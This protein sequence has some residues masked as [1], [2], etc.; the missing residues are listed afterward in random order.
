VSAEDASGA[1]PL[2]RLRNVRKVYRT[3][4]RD[5]VAVADVTFDI[6][7][8]DLVSLAPAT[9]PRLKADERFGELTKRIYR[10]LGM[11]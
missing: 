4:G 10:H 2:I 7:E 1:A 6:F 8:G 9:H 3:A 11:A 5:S